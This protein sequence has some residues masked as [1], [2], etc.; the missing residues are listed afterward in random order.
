MFPN[1]PWDFSVLNINKTFRD[2]YEWISY[3]I[4]LFKERPNLQLII[5]IHPSEVA[6]MESTQTVLDYINNNFSSLPENIKV[7]PPVTDI[8]PYS[9][10]PFTDVGLVFNGTIGLE[11]ALQG[12]PVIVVGD[13]HYGEKGFTYDLP[14]INK[15]KRILFKDISPLTKQKIDFARLYAY[16]YFIKSYIPLNILYYGN[17]LNHG[18]N[19]NSFND[20]AEGNDKFLDHICNYIINNGIIQEW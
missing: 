7:I 17:F 16:F 20:F 8:S 9:L 15:Y 14:S 1:V 5:K 11:M 12:I 18:W 2:V 13:T 10:F 3:T 6:V 19:I 4:E